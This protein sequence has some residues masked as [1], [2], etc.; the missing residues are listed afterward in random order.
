[1]KTLINNLI[2]LFKVNVYPFL[3]KDIENM[4]D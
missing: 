2:L 1:M 3:N 4:G